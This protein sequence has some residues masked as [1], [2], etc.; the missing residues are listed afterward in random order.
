MTGKLVRAAFSP[1]CLDLTLVVV[2]TPVGVLAGFPEY[3]T[4]EESR[5]VP[6]DQCFP[7]CVFPLKI[8]D[9]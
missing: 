5:E 1:I 6:P 3:F 7:R 8:G 4:L 2:V 9:A